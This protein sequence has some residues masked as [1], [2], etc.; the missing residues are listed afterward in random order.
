[1]IVGSDRAVA[2]FTARDG[3]I[4]SEAGTVVACEDYFGWGNLMMNVIVGSKVYRP[5]SFWHRNEFQEED[6]GQTAIILERPWF[7]TRFRLVF[8]NGESL[9]SSS[10]SRAIG[11]KLSL[12]DKRGVVIEV[13]ASNPAPPAEIR[14]H[15]E[16][17]HMRVVVYREGIPDLPLVVALAAKPLA[18]YNRHRSSA[19]P[20][21]APLADPVGRAER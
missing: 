16:H 14:D 18:K 13:F 3:E 19:A 7:S 17:P 9:Q 20:G 4:V 1:V 6:T 12:S 11:G 15:L 8:P 10:V 2:R 5:R 21:G